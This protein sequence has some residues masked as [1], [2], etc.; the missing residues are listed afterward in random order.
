LYVLDLGP[1]Y[2]GYWADN[3]RAISVDGKPTDPQWAAYS[4]LVDALK[5]VE[6]MARPGVRCQHIF[7]AVDEHLKSKAGRGLP[8]HLGHGVGL[9]PHEFPHLNPSWD[10]VLEEG[11]IFTAEPGLY[12]KELAGGIRLEDQYLVTSHGVENLVST[13]RGMI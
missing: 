7:A 9:S 13:P 10:D 1:A 4:T 3:C 11:E 5:I 12:G 2:R 6:Q 8:H